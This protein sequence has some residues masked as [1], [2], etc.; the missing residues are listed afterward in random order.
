MSSE[1][2]DELAPLLCRQASAQYGRARAG[3]FSA[4]PMVSSLVT[5]CSEQPGKRRKYVE[6]EERIKFGNVPAYAQQESSTTQAI[7]AAIIIISELILWLIQWLYGDAVV[8]EAGDRPRSPFLAVYTCIILIR[9]S[10]Y[11]DLRQNTNR[12]KGEKCT[13]MH[14]AGQIPYTLTSPSL[15]L[16]CSLSP[17][18]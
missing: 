6:S 8:V 14:F 13:P 18:S 10:I 17:S 9:R 15:S 2:M 3:A 12:F 1:H 4:F 16:T 5:C 7:V 11:Q